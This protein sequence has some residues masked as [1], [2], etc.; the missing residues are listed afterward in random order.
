[1]NESLAKQNY[2]DSTYARFEFSDINTVNPVAKLILKYFSGTSG[3]VFE[4]GCFPGNFLGVFGLLGYELN[5]IDQTKRTATDLPAWL[6]THQ[7]KVGT[8]DSGDWLTYQSDKQYD[9]VCSF[10]FIEHFQDP[11]AVIRRHLSLLK[12]GGSLLITVP[13]FRGFI[14][15]FL[16]AAL[17]QENLAR[18]NLAA[19][20]IKRWRK[21]LEAEG[22]TIIYSGW[23]GG[24]DFWVE[25]QERSLGQK[26]MLWLV[27]KSGWFIKKL[28]WP[29]SSAYS[30]FAGLIAKKLN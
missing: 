4:A 20:D 28:P 1:M 25:A 15:H 17:D 14:Q 24:F 11:E 27:L 7:F 8:L 19:M 3:D 16:H 2:W 9:V 13:N 5:G 22:W 23:F 10:G 12:P 29:N 30:P 18:H 21:M 26:M 6:K